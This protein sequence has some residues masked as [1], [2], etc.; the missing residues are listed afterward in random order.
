MDLNFDGTGLN[1]SNY[2]D[3]D[4]GTFGYSSNE[5]DEDD[6]YHDENNNSVLSGTSDNSVNHCKQ[7][8]FFGFITSIDLK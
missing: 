8:I 4:H 5:I 3:E 7:K 6:L 2:S 1:D